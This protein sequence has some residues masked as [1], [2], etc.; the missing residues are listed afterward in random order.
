MTYLDCWLSTASTLL[1]QMLAG[2]P[3]LRECAPGADVAT[4]P[5]FAAVLSGAAKGQFTVTVEG[6]MLAAPLFGEGIDQASAWAELL[7]ELA[8][9]AADAFSKSCG[10]NCRVQAFRVT[11]PDR[12]TTRAFELG[13]PLGSWTVLVHDES[14]SALEDSCHDEPLS[15]EKDAVQG[16]QSNSGADLLLDVELDATLRFGCREMPLGEVLE[17]GPGDVI[18][19]DRHTADPADLVVGDK[20]VA[21]GEVVLI[22]GNFGLRVTEVAAPQKRLESIRCLF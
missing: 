13:T 8:E 22:H 12:V 11:E 18:E 19:L 6:E 1:T 2:E 21:R 20:I 9:A 16:M 17:L 3:K 5:S 15:E 14:E 4:G 7:R 10:Q